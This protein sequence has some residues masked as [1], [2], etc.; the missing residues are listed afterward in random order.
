MQHPL[1]PYSLLPELGQPDK[2]EQV[3]PSE[4]DLKPIRSN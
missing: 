3:Y 4:A 1:D 2:I